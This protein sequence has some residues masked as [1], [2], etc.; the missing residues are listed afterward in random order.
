MRRRSAE[1]CVYVP[2]TV[3]LY[4]L[5]QKRDSLVQLEMRYGIHVL[6]AQDDALIPPNFRLDRL[7]VHM[8]GETAVASTAPLTQAP[9]PEPEEEE[10]EETPEVPEVSEAEQEGEEERA[11]SR[12]RRRRRRR[13]DDDSVSRPAAAAADAAEEPG[14]EESALAVENGRADGQE[15]GDD[16]ESEAERRRRRGRRGGRR[17][18]RREAVETG[19]DGP[20]PAADTVEILPAA[21]MAEGEIALGETR[22]TW[23]VEVSAVAIETASL[24]ALAGDAPADV[25]GMA[26][27]ESMPVTAEPA[28]DP[29]PVGDRPAAEETGGSTP[30][31]TAEAEQGVP[32]VSETERVLETA[33]ANQDREPLPAHAVETVTEKPANPRRGWWQRLIQP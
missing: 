18:G 30:P 5:N 22:A 3:A 28:S 7:R 4:I 16:K 10:A 21:Q 11:R 13:H 17:R 2:T 33:S 12:R 20:R 25:A 6:V 23:P 1:I 26:A 24:P 9:P 32:Y 15:A 14:E 29:Q 31:P 8:P 27:G 19:F